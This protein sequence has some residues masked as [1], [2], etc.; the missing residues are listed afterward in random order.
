MRSP[1][2]FQ[3]RDLPALSHRLSQRARPGPF[4]GR[5]TMPRGPTL[6]AHRPTM[7][8]GQAPRPARPHAPRGS[9]E[10]ALRFRPIV[11]SGVAPAAPAR[12][13]P[14]PRYPPSGGRSS[15]LS[16]RASCR[17]QRSASRRAHSS[18]G[19]S[20]GSRPRPPP[21]RAC[22]SDPAAWSRCSC[23]LRAACRA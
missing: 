19:H 20:P 17:P 10:P 23:S 1:L 3:P 9:W 15:A 18:S 21:P 8:A 11:P 13:A 22:P 14:Q 5:K 7:M 2:A 6:D 16:T 4:T 12:H